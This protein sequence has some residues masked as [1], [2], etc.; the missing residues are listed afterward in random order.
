M[1]AKGNCYDNA[2]N[3]SFFHSLKTEL[4]Y[5]TR[6]ATRQEAKS[7]VFA[8][9]EGFYVRRLRLPAP[10]A[11]IPYRVAESPA[12]RGRPLGRSP[13]EIRPACP[14]AGPRS[15]ADQVQVLELDQERVST[16]SG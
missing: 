14:S 2:A 1:S 12:R 11:T 9:I 5:R 8:W 4:V 15:S 3:E 7:A 13:E 6:F 16:N 10:K